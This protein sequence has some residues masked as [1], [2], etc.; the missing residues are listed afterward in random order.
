MLLKKSSF[1]EK[2]IL[3]HESFSTL[4]N[5]PSFLWVKCQFLLKNSRKVLEENDQKE[6]KKTLRKYERSLGYV[7][8]REPL[9]ENLFVALS[10]K[11]KEINE[12]VKEICNIIR[13][14]DNNSTVSLNYKEFLTVGQFIQKLR[15]DNFRENRIIYS[16]TYSAWYNLKPLSISNNRQLLL[17]YLDR[18]IISAKS[19]KNSNGLNVIFFLDWFL[20]YYNDDDSL[21]AR[22][23]LAHFTNMTVQRN[24]LKILNA[25]KIIEERN[26]FDSKIANWFIKNFYNDFKGKGYNN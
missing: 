25:L 22:K 14:E 12:K 5:K 4:K 6:N 3:L 20:S 2:K 15:K 9:F 11:N 24:S 8:R 21:E 16:C 13:L 1:L 18:L 10:R 17:L 26:D 23:C 7:Y 19:K